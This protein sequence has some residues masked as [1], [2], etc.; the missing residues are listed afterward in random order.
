MENLENILGCEISEETEAEL[1]N[2]KGEEE[3]ENE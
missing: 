1:S 2:G 3:E